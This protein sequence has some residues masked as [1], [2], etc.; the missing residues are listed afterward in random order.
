MDNVNINGDIPIATE[1]INGAH[2]Q[3]MIV[4]DNIADIAIKFIK[5][6]I[7][8]FTFELL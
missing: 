2:Y 7:S 6:V 1:E 5:G 8:R 3:K 4:V